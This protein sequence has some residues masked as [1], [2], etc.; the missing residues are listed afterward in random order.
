MAKKTI[1]ATG[2]PTTPVVRGRTATGFPGDPIDKTF[3]VSGQAPRRAQARLVDP[4]IARQFD[5]PTHAH[6]HAHGHT[7]KHAHHALPERP[8]TSGGPAS[9]NLKS[10]S[11]L[12]RSPGKRET[13]DDLHLH[14]LGAHGKGTTF[15]DFPLARPLPSPSAST[16]SL[17]P[18]PFSL[19]KS[20]L[21][22]APSSDV[23]AS[24]TMQS[25]SM[26]NQMEI[27]MA[28]GSP[29]HPPPQLQTHGLDN[30]GQFELRQVGSP[31]RMSP[32]EPLSDPNAPQKQQKA[33]KW[34]LLGGLFGG[35]KKQASTAP[36]YQV[37]PEGVPSTAAETDSSQAV[38]PTESGNGKSRGRGRSNS[39]KKSKSKPDLKRS[40]TAPH[41]SPM[42][43]DFR[44]GV[45]A[46]S[47][48]NPQ[49]TL[50]GGPMLNVDIP[51]IQMERYSVMFGSVLKPNNTSS[52]ALLAR[53]QATL[54]KL[55]TVN[56][57]LQA[58]VFAATH[59]AGE[60]T[61]EV[62]EKELEEKERLLRPRRAT[63]PQPTRSPAFSLF[64][65]T[66]S[67]SAAREPLPTHE[68]R[69]KS[70][71]Q[72]S[73]TAPGAISPARASFET[74]LKTAEGR[75]PKT[76]LPEAPPIAPPQPQ[77]QTNKQRTKPK[78]Q[79][80]VTQFSQEW[81][82][83]DLSSP[84]SP[85]E[86]ENG[87][88][89]TAPNFP[90]KP[91]VYSPAWVM[92]TRHP[93]AGAES[94]SSTESTINSASSAATS[95][96]TGSHLD[97]S[98][99]LEVLLPPPPIGRGRAG[100]IQSTISTSSMDIPIA[101]SQPPVR[102]RANTTSGNR[103]DVETIY[104]RRPEDNTESLPQRP[105][106]DRQHSN[107]SVNLQPQHM[108]PLEEVSSPFSFVSSGPEEGRPSVERSSGEHR[109]S[110][111]EERLITAANVSIAR[112]ISVSRQQRQLLVPIQK[113]SSSHSPTSQRSAVPSPMKSVRSPGGD[114]YIS[115]P[116]DSNRVTAAM[117]AEAAPKP[118]MLADRTASRP[119]VNVTTDFTG[120]GERLVDSPVRALTPTLVVV[121]GPGEPRIRGQVKKGS[122]I[123]AARNATLGVAGQSG[124]N[125]ELQHRRS[126]RGVVER[127]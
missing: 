28:L 31:V 38:P 15:Y 8:N 93:N 109:V 125:M 100:T 59:T 99:N 126:E 30:Q 14:P 69:H 98:E 106:G 114:P 117:N 108:T 42:D 121:D 34:K 54:D 27:G 86:S 96:S 10:S 26:E 94:T 95:V 22:L 110:E 2:S 36:F 53:R 4:D 66:P 107:M 89:H 24:P 48:G 44:A 102:D 111:D 7:N 118:L 43:F 60:G 120:L 119:R 3:D 65:N 49:I 6:A 51:S 57:A 71:L 70:P 47:N 23:A 39:V 122:P 97:K 5:F 19:R 20:S 72:R 32:V 33:S 85:M 58:K 77:S 62:Q 25:A 17:S 12:R 105:I 11:S 73:N 127:A 29:S 79:P 78:H 50:D 52:S 116:L 46:Q 74:S 115:A 18:A 76:L 83:L 1:S 40:A 37:Q 45:N 112:Q 88:E 67:R 91:K 21:K 92:V 63:S 82:H 55:K 68:P 104:I 9:K 16:R 101:F 41:N 81:S 13:R 64:P 113:S 84:V 56:E 75:K 90:T 124:G 80:I 35:G 103:T 61:N 87:E 123:G